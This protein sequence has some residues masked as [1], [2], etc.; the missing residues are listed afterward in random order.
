[1]AYR[2]YFASNSDRSFNISPEQGDLLPANANGT[3]LKISFCPIVYGKAYT[4]MLVVEVGREQSATCLILFCLLG[5]RQPMEICCSRCIT[6]LSTSTK[7][8]EFTIGEQ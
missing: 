6:T 4:A 3:L 5:Q 1:M 7:S 8:L 2:A